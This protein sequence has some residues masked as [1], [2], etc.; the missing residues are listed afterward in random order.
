[1]RV[2]TYNVHGCVGMDRV[3]SEA[4][5][6]DVIGELAAE[7]VG[8]QELDVS[9]AR[10]AGV[11][12]PALIAEQLGWHYLFE[13]AFSVGG[14]LFGNAI[15]SRYP[16][17][18]RQ[19]VSF[20]GSSPWYCRENRMALFGEVATESGPVQIMNTHLGLG[21]S[22]RVQ[23]AQQLAAQLEDLAA[24]TA[25]IVL[26]DLNCLPQS[27]PYRTLAH[28]LSDHRAMT[29]LRREY[30]TF[31]TSFPLLSV[32]HVLV[33]GA[34]TIEQISVHRTPAARVA[35]DHFPLVAEV[36]RARFG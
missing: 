12:Q 18:F 2:A 19:A 34:L 29:Q 28:A 26:G 23:Q 11:N 4:R 24:N 36:T 25:T 33:N 21:R 9:R 31:P 1:M 15:L 10:S 6:A 35:S 32:D 22:E 17:L 13:P 3:R 14:E 7:I 16:I 30:R 8:L 5:I 27:R 20:S